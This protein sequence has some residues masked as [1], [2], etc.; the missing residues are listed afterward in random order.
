MHN[1][2]DTIPEWSDDKRM[3]FYMQ[4]FKS[5]RQVNPE[6]WDQKM[7]FWK[8]VFQ[9]FVEKDKKILLTVKDIKSDIFLRLSSNNQKKLPLGW[10]TVVQHLILSLDVVEAEKFVN[11]VETK[12]EQGFIGWMA[13]LFITKPASW[14][15]SKMTSSSSHNSDVNYQQNPSKIPL[16]EDKKLV[17]VNTVKTMA[18]E[19]KEEVLSSHVQFLDLFKT[20][21][22][23]K[24]YFPSIP[25]EEIHYV[26]L[27]L[28]QKKVATILETKSGTGVRF[29]ESQKPE[30][31][32]ASTDMSIIQ[33][34][35]TVQVLENQINEMQNAVDTCMEKA[36]EHVKK[37]QKTNS[38]FE[39]RRKKMLE[40]A[41]VK[42]GQMAENSTKLLNNIQDVKSEMDVLD[43]LQAGAKTLQSYTSKLQKM[44]PEETINSIAEIVADYSE[45]S[46]L[47]TEGMPLALQ[48]KQDDK[49]ID[50]ELMEL[51]NEIA[52][53]LPVEEKSNKNPPSATSPALTI[54]TKV[55][56]VEKQKKLAVS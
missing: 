26:L 29:F 53:E 46:E 43:A 32:D 51:Q 22:E 7:N 5:N 1:Y 52:E 8:N 16:P 2:F 34:K 11:Y 35:E 40:E 14:V 47:I 4:D 37:D 20:P 18:N 33:L 28:Q 9:T 21:T 27:Y 13:N 55:K 25:T 17:V 23:I 12:D 15:W 36:R 6:D 44:N 10:Q 19:W 41:L 42:R 30:S 24:Q 48:M 38:K 49:S 31:Y 3:N 56:K 45:I 54:Q 50:E 39:L